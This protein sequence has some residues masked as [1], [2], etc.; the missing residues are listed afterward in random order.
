MLLYAETHYP[1]IWPSRFALSE[2]EIIT[3]VPWWVAPGQRIPLVLLVK[4]AHGYPV[5]V[6]SVRVAVRNATGHVGQWT[7]S[8][9]QRIRERLWF[10]VFHL[11]SLPSGDY[12]VEPVIQYISKGRRRKAI[13]D[14]YRLTSHAPFNLHVGHASWPHPEGWASGDAH[15]HTSYTSDQAEFGPPVSVITDMAKAM[16]LQWAA[17]TDHSYDLDDS[18]DSYLVND[19]E[20]P[21]WNAF[22]EEVAADESGVCLIAGEEVSC[23]NS[24]DR[25]V[26]LLALNTA[27]HI[28]G[29]GDSAEVLTPQKPD[30]TIPE[31][32][33]RVNGQ[34]GLAVA[35]HPGFRPIAAEQLLFRRGGWTWPDVS[36]DNLGGLQIWN[37]ARN[38]EF[39]RG[40]RMWTQLLLQGKQIPVLAGNDSH[41]SFG[42]FRQVSIPWLFMTDDTQHLFARA[43]TVVEAP[44]CDKATVME[45]LAHGKS[46][47]SDGPSLLMYAES[48][49]DYHSIG[50]RVDEPLH[51]VVLEAVSIED[52]GGIERIGIGVGICG[53][54]A[55]SWRWFRFPRTPMNAE[56]EIR[57]TLDKPGY[58]RAEVWTTSGASALTNPI[59]VTT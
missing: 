6:D 10:Q 33:E 51:S 23:G 4:D 2:P 16:D 52:W 1:R 13:A 59:Y 11:P 42:R 26:H 8:I 24:S 45:S 15:V 44:V 18:E 7:F 40:M 39:R 48:D 14:N 46:Y 22:Q 28:S 41:G 49:S 47:L 25:N 35:A 56:Q 17:L 32:V 21:R 9:N 34:G 29:K 31:V 36:V 54:Q 55:E 5:H 20:L 43:R 3:D 30:L 12:L 53:E 57:F 50:A 58:V 27:E 38:R 19:P 37:G